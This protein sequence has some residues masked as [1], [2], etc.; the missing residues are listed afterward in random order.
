[1]RVAILIVTGTKK[2][3]KLKDRKDGEENYWKKWC[4]TVS[5]LKIIRL[6]HHTRSV[7]NK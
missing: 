2:L 3:S 6:D 5:S 7:I 4:D 1:M